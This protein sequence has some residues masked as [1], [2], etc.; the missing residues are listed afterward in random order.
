LQA[1]VAQQLVDVSIVG[2]FGKPDSSRRSA[3]VLFVISAAHFDLSASRLD[4]RHQREKSV[5]R[6][7]G[8]DVDRSRILKRSKT[9][10]NVSAVAVPK[11]V[12]AGAEVIK[13][14][15]RGIVQR[16]A[17]ASSH[18]LFFAQLDEPR[19]MSDI[20]L[21]QERIGQHLAQ[22]RREPESYSSLYPVLETGA[23]DV[24]QREG[25]LADRLKQPV[26]FEE[27]GVLGVTHKRQMR[28]K[29]DGEQSVWHSGN[30][31][32][33]MLNSEEA[34]RPCIRRARPCI[35]RARPCIR[36]AVPE[37]FTI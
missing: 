27:L 17:A 5:R 2:A 21:L 4:P 30:S 23:Q 34:L 13:I 10:E 12:P 26:F 28:V 37:T 22:R 33:S 1:C 31:K 9:R 14:H 15:L 25:C 8:D 19:Q 20:A 7:A 35:R 16:L 29:N 32:G 11:Q 24:K 18:D 36:H 3:K 6:S